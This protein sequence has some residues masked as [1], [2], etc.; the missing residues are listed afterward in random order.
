MNPKEELVLLVQERMKERLGWLGLKDWE[1]NMLM[2]D[3]D[4]TISEVLIGFHVSRDLKIRQLLS[5]VMQEVTDE[6]TS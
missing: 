6:R 1:V 3:V 5:K 4:F 2:A